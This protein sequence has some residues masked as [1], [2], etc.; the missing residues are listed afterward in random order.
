MWILFV[1]LVI[2]HAV[3][4]RSADSVATPAATSDPE[5]PY[6]F[7]CQDTPTAAATPPTAGKI[8]GPSID[9]ARAM[10]TVFPRYD[11]HHKEARWCVGDGPA[12][13]AMVRRLSGNKRR[14][15]TAIFTKRYQEAGRPHF[16]LLTET[17]PPGRQCHACTIVLGGAVFHR[18]DGNWRL[19][20]GNRAIC[21]A[22]SW[23][24]APTEMSLVAVGPDRHGVAI[25][26]G[27]TSQGQ[28]A[29]SFT[30]IAPVGDKLEQVLRIDE[31]AGDN[32]GAC[33]ADHTPGSPVGWP[34]WSYDSRVQFMAGD[35]PQ[36]HDIAL[37]TLGTRLGDDGDIVH[38]EETRRFRF[39][40]FYMEG[41]A[42][43]QPPEPHF[44]I[45]VGAFARYA[46]ARDITK[47]L[48]KMDL[49]AFVDPVTADGESTLYRVR[50]GYY[51]ERAAAQTVLDRLRR[52]GMTGMVLSLPGRTPQ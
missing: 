35:H 19:K 44:A 34:C 5:T 32:A 36:F 12:T 25:T 20:A 15:A 42:P 11:S 18:V 10:A 50:V 38:I 47:K 4:A 52:S 22:G 51:T 1:V 6:A 46:T 37:T 3:P 9:T 26:H 8:V 17:R 24:R 7:S 45:Q 28:T 41:P 43:K 30:L 14:Y 16:I 23:G 27:Y 40:G 2:G 31:A 33:D 13:P 29:E 48:G 39:A 49:S 21:R